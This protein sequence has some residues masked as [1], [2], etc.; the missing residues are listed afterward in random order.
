[1]P[2]TPPVAAPPAAETLSFEA[3][4]AELDAIVAA[5]ESGS[6]P[7]EES[8]AAYKRGA[9]LVRAAQARLSTAEQQIRILEDGML[10]PFEV[11]ASRAGAGEADT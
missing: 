2:K 11:S 1:M 4:V 7:L 10:K 5:M 6:L 3:A 9:E 8:L